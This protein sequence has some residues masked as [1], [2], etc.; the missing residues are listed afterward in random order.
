MS[1]IFF[2]HSSVNGHLSCFHVLAIVN[3]VAVHIGVHVSFQIMVFAR[4][5]PR[6]GIAGWYGSSIFIFGF[7][8]NSIL[9]SV[10]IV[11][12][13][14]PTNSI[15]NFLLSTPSLTFIVCKLFDVGNSDQCEVVYLKVVLI[16]ISLIISDVGHLFVWWFFIYLFPFIIS[17]S[18]FL[19]W[20]FCSFSYLP[21]LIFAYA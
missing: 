10:E 5:V 14:I 4:Y 11:L 15:G 7:L 13:Y 1:L 12:I 6:S 17:L 20:C 9:F 21:Y 19:F 8:R 3:S 16:W 18:A 2:N